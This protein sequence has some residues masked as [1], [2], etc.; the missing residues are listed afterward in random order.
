MAD[1]TYRMTV[2]LSDGSSIVAGTFV[3]PQGPQGPKG[4]TGAQGPQGIQGPQGPQGPMGELCNWEVANTST[5]VFQANSVYIVKISDVV[6]LCS[7]TEDKTGNISIINADS[8]GISIYGISILSNGKM[9]ANA[10][11]FTITDSISSE[12]IPIANTEFKYVKVI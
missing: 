7:T 3:A 4:D 10:K 5:F 9:S 6:G 12:T 8:L 11:L 2:T 1:K